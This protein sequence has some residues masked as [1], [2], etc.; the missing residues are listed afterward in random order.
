MPIKVPDLNDLH[1]LVTVASTGSIGQAATDLGLTQP[2]ASR[3]IAALERSLRVQLLRRGARGSTLTPSGRVIVEWATTLLCATERFRESVDA[4]GQERNSLL[5]AALSMTIAEHYAPR[6]LAKVRQES[7]QTV[8]TVSMANSSTVMD[9]VDSGRVDVGLIEAPSVRQ[10]LQS[11]RIGTDALAV[12]VLPDHPWATQHD[13]GA[14]DLASAELLVREHGSGARETLDRALAAVG[15]SVIPALE[16]A[17]NTALKS[18]ALAGIGPVVLPAIALAHELESGM[19]VEVKFEAI[20]LRRPLTIVW[21]D[22][23]SLSRE[24]VG[25]FLNAARTDWRTCGRGVTRLSR[26]SPSRPARTDRLD[27]VL[28]G[29]SSPA[30]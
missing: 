10:S 11:R 18:A 20:T 28:R 12:A 8:V 26:P 6:W 13:L 22:A 27:R 4:L 21:S 19:L 3:R 14:D 15:H 5:H 1:L 29:P 16:L 30:A 24:A 17:S 2:S 23:S 9:M 7:P 25:L